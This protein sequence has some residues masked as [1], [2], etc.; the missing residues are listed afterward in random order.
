MRLDGR[1]PLCLVQRS[2]RRCFLSLSLSLLYP[3]P[4]L[5]YRSIAARCCCRGVGAAIN[6]PRL[7]PYRRFVPVGARP[8]RLSHPRVATSSSPSRASPTASSTSSKSR[9]L[10]CFPPAMKSF[11]HDCS[12]Y[13]SASFVARP[14]PCAIICPIC[15]MISQPRRPS[16]YPCSFQP[17]PS[18]APILVLPAT[19]TCLGCA[20]FAARQSTASKACTVTEPAAHVVTHARLTRELHALRRRSGGHSRRSPSQHGDTVR[21]RQVAAVRAWL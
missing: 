16:Y 17:S 12:R 4:S 10:S 11:S 15:T 5:C 1:G 18:S 21:R 14:R 8:R 19:F 3:L 9:S 7:G 13:H 2:Q 6:P 20:P